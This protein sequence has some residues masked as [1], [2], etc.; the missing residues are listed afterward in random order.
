MT[1]LFHILVFNAT[2][3]FISLSYSLQESMQQFMLI[4]VK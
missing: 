4:A 2:P 1:P 3:H